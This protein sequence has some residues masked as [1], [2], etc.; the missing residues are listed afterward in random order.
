M[1]NGTIKIF[2]RIFA[3]TLLSSLLIKCLNEL[4]TTDLFIKAI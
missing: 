4:I 2:R 3:S 1:G